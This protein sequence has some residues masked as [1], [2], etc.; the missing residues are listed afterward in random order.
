MECHC[1]G[2]A[3]VRR[4]LYT[5]EVFLQFTEK[6]MIERW[7][8]LG[9]VISADGTPLDSDGNKTTQHLN[10]ALE[11]ELALRHLLA[12]RLKLPFPIKEMKNL[13]YAQ[14]LMLGDVDQHG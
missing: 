7:R 9:H 3:K 11:I 4:N 5:S 2:C 8:A 6:F 14:M 12:D 10:E 13:K 1:H